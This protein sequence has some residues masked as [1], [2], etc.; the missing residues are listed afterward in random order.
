MISPPP[1]VVARQNEA[2]N[3]G[4]EEAFA[5]CYASDV[6]VSDILEDHVIADGLEELLNLYTSIRDHSTSLHCQIVGR[7]TMGNIV[8]DR[9]IISGLPAGRD[10]YAI[11]VY[12]VIEGKITRVWM[13]QES[14]SIWE[15]DEEETP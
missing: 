13:I 3:A 1:D 7:M 9:E 14:H 10:L 5:A 4:D 15:E 6:V 12:E 8:I 2:Y 11:A